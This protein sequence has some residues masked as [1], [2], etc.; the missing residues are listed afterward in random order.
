MYVASVPVSALCWP[1]WWECACVYVVWDMVVLK[2]ESWTGRFVVVWMII[3]ALWLV[4]GGVLL[5]Y[6]FL[7]SGCGH[8]IAAVNGKRWGLYWLT[9]TSLMPFTN[10]VFS[11]SPYL[12]CCAVLYSHPVSAIVSGICSCFSFADIFASNSTWVRGSWRWLRCAL[13]SR[14]QM[15]PAKHCMGWGFCYRKA[16]DF[17][18]LFSLI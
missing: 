1:R 14:S 17:A 16:F 13:D 11:L 18:T 7:C 4:I 3:G 6:E 12:F 9:V 10:T 8:F 5:R 2:A 15:W